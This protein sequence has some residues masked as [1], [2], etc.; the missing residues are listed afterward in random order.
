MLIASSACERVCALAS[1]VQI[2]WVV[3]REEFGIG[4]TLWLAATLVQ[5]LSDLGI[6][7]ML[8]QADDGDDERLGRV[9]QTM[10]LTRGV[11]CTAILL[12]IAPVCARA[13]GHADLTWAF[14]AAGLLPA[15]NG[16][17][18]RDVVRLQRQYK[19]GPA[20]LVG[21][22]PALLAAVAAYPLATWLQDFRVF[23]V[24]AFLRQITATAA[25]HLVASRPY[26]LGWDRELGARFTRF[27]WPLV[28]NGILVYAGTQ[29]G[30][31]IVACF[32]GPE[33][34]A[35]FAIATSLTWL[36][37][38]QLDSILRTLGMPYLAARKHA[39]ER[40]HDGVERFTNAL[41]LVCIGVLAGF[42]LLAPDI[43]H[44]L[45]RG[46]YDD[47]APLVQILGAMNV[48]RL[49]RLA[50]ALTALSLGNAKLLMTT[51]VTRIVQLALSVAAASRA[52][53]LATICLGMLLTDAASVPWAYRL[54][55]RRH[56][57]PCSVYRPGAIVFC[58]GFAAVG[59]AWIVQVTL[60]GSAGA[61]AAALAIVAAF[62]ATAGGSLRGIADVLRTTR[63]ARVS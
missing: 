26:R 11:M 47:A 57:I 7:R 55:V 13:F 19:F 21:S 14:A 53:S 24:I 49:F 1:S 35:A 18:H 42:V 48:A 17:R 20:A 61:S 38:A 31:L 30:N 41:S 43:V 8:V 3:S 5:M 58:S 16:L 51:N 9:A 44:V 52:S 27:G 22:V 23:L 45:Y 54:A 36:P 6:D 25:T 56:R 15:I 33:R 39:P 2:A 46:K 50:P 59:L 29:G 34:L 60:G 4:A 62:A 12:L 40:F 28:V 37:M 32:Y 63:L 10:L